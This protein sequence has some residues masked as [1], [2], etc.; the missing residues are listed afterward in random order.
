MT[1]L[2]ITRKEA[3]QRAGVHV[4]TVDYWRRSGKLKTLRDG[5]GRVSIDPEELS[6]LITPQLEEGSGA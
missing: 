1:E 3:A 4:R 5:L 6:T 2:L